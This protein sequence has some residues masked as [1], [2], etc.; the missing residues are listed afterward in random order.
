M[1]RTILLSL[2]LIFLF[3]VNESQISA[4]SP[5]LLNY[6]AVIRDNNANPVTDTDVLLEFEILQGSATGTLVYAESHNLTTNPY[7]LVSAIIG[8]GTGEYFIADIDWSQGPFFLKT[9]VDGQELSNTQLLS[10]PFALYADRAANGVSD[11]EKDNWNQ[12]Y[13]WGNHAEAGYSPITNDFTRDNDTIY[14][15]SGNVGIGTKDPRSTLSVYGTTPNDSAIFEV[16][17]NDGYTVFAVYN[18]GVRINIDE[19]I[20]VKGSKGGFAIGGFDRS[21]G[22]IQE[23]L[24]VTSDSTRVYV[25]QN[26]SK[27][28]KGGFAIGGFDGS[29][30]LT[31]DY[32]NLTPD[33]YFIGHGSGSA[34]TSGLYNSFF[35]YNSGMSTTSGS[36]NIFMGYQGGFQ[37]TTGSYNINI[38][39]MAG[40]YNI[41]GNY[42]TLIGYRSGYYTGVGAT[43][44]PSYN[45]YIGYETGYSNRSGEYNTFI[46]HRAGKSGES[47]SGNRNVFVGDSAGVANISGDNNI[48]VGKG[49]GAFNELGD[50]NVILGSGAGYH[51]NGHYNVFIGY[52]SGYNNLSGA[53]SRY[54]KWNTFMGYRSGYGNTTG[55]QNLAIG[56]EAGLNNQAASNQLFIGNNAGRQLTD[57][58]GNTFIGHS[59]GEKGL[60][61]SNSTI[62]GYYAGTNGTDGDYNVYVGYAAGIDAEG[63]NNVFV[64]EGAGHDLAA[65]D[66]NVMIGRTAGF[67]TTSGSG[68][69]FIGHRAGYDNAYS[70]INNKLYIA[71]DNTFN[72]EPLIYG[73]FASP[74]VIINGRTRASTAYEFYVNGQSGGTTAWNSTSDARLKEGIITIPGALQKV[75]R[76]RGVNFEWTDKQLGGEGSQMG[77]IAQE[78]MEVIPEVVNTEGEYYSMQYAP[79]TALL[80]EAIKEQQKEIEILK[81][82]NSTVN[83]LVIQN[84]DMQNEIDQLKNLVFDLQTQ[85]GLIITKER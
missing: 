59:A 71:N 46:G 85:I 51:N 41:N 68:N 26:A 67:G 64:G 1:K 81:E 13:Q 12:A 83:D 48:F 27:G 52:Q 25:N 20:A 37:N 57:G 44:D 19:Q 61:I 49:A 58:Y 60:N 82:K 53:D 77:F 56:Y 38:G 31:F 5:R 28:P 16:K 36:D 63:D 73:D 65:G 42:N 50:Y 32:V 80:V 6:Q 17:N 29:K 22:P 23:Y 3:L 72:S 75:L 18:E 10:V 66:N 43:T 69:V 70:A 40:Y 2:V 79:V 62:I 24:R 78:A 35:G 11:G 7:G 14:Y 21:K 8:N 34:I 15:I 74:Y 54:S 33:N 30:G 47:A 55:W 9:S 4:Q 84:H 39:N 45:T 76:M